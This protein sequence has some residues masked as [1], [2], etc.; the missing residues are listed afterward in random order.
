MKDFVN[1][2]QEQIR[3]SPKAFE[4]LLEGVI[5]MAGMGLGSQL[6]NFKI[7]D[8]I[9]FLT[10]AVQGYS[11]TWLF[12]EKGLKWK[13][14]GTPANIE[15]IQAFLMDNLESQMEGENNEN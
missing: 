2:T 6:Q 10:M 7:E 11:I 1:V 5:A 15:E 3:I 9:A 12:C 14:D 8:E 13:C 4:G